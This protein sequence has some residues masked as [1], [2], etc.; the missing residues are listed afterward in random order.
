M[1]AVEFEDTEA[2]PW[3]CV[4]GA[5]QQPDGTWKAGGG[6]GGIVS[7]EPQ[8]RGPW[9]NFGGWGWPRFLCLGGRVHGEG[10]AQVRLIDAVGRTI[11]DSVDDGIALL[12]S[13]EPVEMP[14][15][16]ELRDN[17]GAVVAIQVW[18]PEPGSGGRPAADPTRTVR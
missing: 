18:P 16:I 9:A 5:V 1:L 7:P 8:P 15:R 14:C 12:L 10:I 4:F 13:N 2:R 6:S 11:E 3:H 17:G